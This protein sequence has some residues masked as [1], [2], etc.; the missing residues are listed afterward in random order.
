MT[1]TQNVDIGGYWTNG[2]T[3]HPG[4]GVSQGVLRPFP[5][6]TYTLV[7]ADAWGHVE[8]LY[9]QVV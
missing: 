4:G 7:V 3:Q 2:L 6:G 5:R 1:D 8:T 9:F